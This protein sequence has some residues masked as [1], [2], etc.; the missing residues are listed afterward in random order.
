MMMKITNPLLLVILI[1]VSAIITGCGSSPKNES[2]QSSLVDPQGVSLESVVVGRQY[3][4]VIGDSIAAGNPG[5]TGRLSPLS[6]SY[7]D[8]PGQINYELTRIKGIPFINHGIGS[9]TSSD[10][11]LRWGRDVL[12]QEIDIGDGMNSTMG[13]AT[14]LPTIVVLIV[15]TN[16]ILQFVDI[17]IIKDN[18]RY[19]AQSSIDNDIDLY[20]LNIG[21]NLYYNTPALEHT[22]QLNEWLNG[23]FREEFTKTVLIDY[24][25]WSSTNPGNCDQLR[26]GYY[27]DYVHPNIEGYR[28]LSEYIA[29]FME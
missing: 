21:C 11:F 22:L 2:R 1:S 15:G 23:E 17:S 16:D 26:P 27:T 12:A 9:Q 5:R 19:F 6:E 25:N 24:F 29:T 28:E 20:I 3:G 8:M 10:V 4:I 7:I 14:D 18:F 13:F